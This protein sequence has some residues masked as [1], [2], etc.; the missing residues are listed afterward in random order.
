MQNLPLSLF[1]TI[2]READ[3]DFNRLS[4]NNLK[5][6]QQR[7]QWR[8]KQGAAARRSGSAVRGFFPPVHKVEHSFGVFLRGRMAGVGVLAGAEQPG[9]IVGHHAGLYVSG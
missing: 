6:F 9:R 8:P 2:I 3:E 7:R 5:N 4:K 1:A